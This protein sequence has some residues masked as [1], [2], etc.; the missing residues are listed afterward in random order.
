MRSYHIQMAENLKINSERIFFGCIDV[1]RRYNHM[2][3]KRIKK[4]EWTLNENYFF[5]AIYYFGAHIFT[6]QLFCSGWKLRKKL[7]SI[8]ACID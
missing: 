7:K 1:T 3:V 8:G 5:H 4:N 2:N 6:S